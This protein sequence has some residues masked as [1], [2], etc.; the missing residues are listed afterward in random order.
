MTQCPICKLSFESHSTSELIECS[1]TQIEDQENFEE[2][3]DI[4]PNCKYKICNHSNQQLADCILA[5][6]K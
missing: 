5:Y 2:I 4:C 1:R 3:Q 6:F